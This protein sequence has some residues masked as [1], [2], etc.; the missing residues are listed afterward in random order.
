[1]STQS[2]AK[3]NWGNY[4]RTELALLTPILQKHSFTL[5]ESQ[6]HIAGE[7]FLMQAITT[8]SGRKLILLG[9]DGN[10]NRVVI[11]A[12]RDPEGIRE[13]SHERICRDVLKK[14]NFAGK[15]FHIPT[16]VSFFKNRGFV[17]SIQAFIDQECTFLE[18]PLE[19]QFAYALQSFKAQESAHATTWKHRALI[20]GTFG[21]RNAKTYLYNF[22]SF[23]ANIKIAL[24]KNDPLHNLLDEAEKI[25][26]ENTAVIEQYSGF[27][28]HTDF[29][30]H[31]FRIK[32][33]VIYLLD[34]SSLTFGNKYEGWARFL[35]FMAL[36]NPKLEHALVKYVQDNRT[37]EESV[38]LRMMRIYRLGE[39][40]WYYVQTLDKSSGNLRELNSARIHLWSNVL[41]HI[42]RNE[43]VPKTLIE[44][45]KTKR[46]ALRSEDEKERQKGLH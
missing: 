34:N 46:D 25:L 21:I 6:P 5:E 2:D 44:T 1:M 18:R 42:V 13:L 8:A 40:I 33:G 16:E 4:C 19:K 36:Y 7:R 28:T 14:I 30:P 24:P 12:S 26:R 38:S 43:P 11:K 39:I 37:L 10:G 20:E 23:L 17:I 3:A 41:A 32:D 22:S 9:Q 27:L 15:V 29:V 35:N 45:Y 31:N